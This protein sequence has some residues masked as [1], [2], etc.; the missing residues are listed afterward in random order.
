MCCGHCLRGDIDEPMDMPINWI[1]K[2]LDGIDSIGSVTFT[3]GEPSLADDF[4]EAFV[5][6]AVENDKEINGCFIATNGKVYSQKIV[7]SMMKLQLFS[8]EEMNGKE[9]FVNYNDRYI[10][11]DEEISNFAI[12]V[13]LD[14]FHEAIPLSNLIKYKHSGFYTNIMETNFDKQSVLARG[15]GATIRGAFQRNIWQLY[16]SDNDD[17]G[18]EAESVYINVDG[19]VFADCDLSYEDAEREEAL[20]NIEEQDLADILDAKAEECR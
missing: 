10:L 14:K 3:G 15:R 17:R 4:I 2:I 6:Y 12:A 8:C 20:G 7:D 16:F 11:E 9:I 19:S 18:Y 5:D 13:S 1:P